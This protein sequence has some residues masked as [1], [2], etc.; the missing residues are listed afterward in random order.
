LAPTEALFAAARSAAHR[1]D[2]QPR[3]T[4]SFSIVGAMFNKIRETVKRRLLQS[5]EKRAGKI[6]HDAA[7]RGEALRERGKTGATGSSGGG[8]EPGG[9]VF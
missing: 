1:T 9:R 5:R 4:A 3:F 7:V 6:A 8:D 2:P